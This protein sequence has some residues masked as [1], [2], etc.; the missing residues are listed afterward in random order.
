MKATISKSR[1]EGRIKAPSSKS[2]TIRGLM[3]AALAKGESEI[4]H[5]LSSDDTEASLSVLGRLGIRIHKEGDAWQVA[6]GDFH[7]P[8][9]D[10]FCGESAATLRFMTAICSLVPGRCRLVAGPSLS[11]RPVR[12][13]VEALQRLGVT[14]SCK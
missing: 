2:Y 12:D 7:K 3:C 9:S 4:V 1:V 5:P 11:K 10:L 8:E 13:L 6:G 14:C